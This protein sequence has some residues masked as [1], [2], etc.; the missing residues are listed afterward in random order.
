MLDFRKPY[1]ILFKDKHSNWTSGDDERMQPFL[2]IEAQLEKEDGKTYLSYWAI[3]D[4]RGHLLEG[5]VKKDLKNGIVFDAK[6][7]G[8]ILTMTEL[9]MEQFEKRIR[10]HLD[11]NVSDM[12]NDLDDV[13]VWCRQQVGIN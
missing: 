7:A 6:N 1:V 12:L 5:T 11:E 9:T 8:Y 4:E 10:P 2:G 13:Y 3:G